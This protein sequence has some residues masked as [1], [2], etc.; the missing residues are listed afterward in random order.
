V[1][2][3][4]TPTTQQTPKINPNTKQNPQNNPK[5]AH[6]KQPTPTQTKNKKLQTKKPNQLTTQP[7][8]ISP[9]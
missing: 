4:P 9:T 8:Q 2:N 6:P 7:A 5:E 3:N 1:Q